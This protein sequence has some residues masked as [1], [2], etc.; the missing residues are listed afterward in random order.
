MRNAVTEMVF[1]CSGN[2]GT[3][4]VSKGGIGTDFVKDVLNE[5]DH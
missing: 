1:K 4:G 3:Q 5:V 2:N